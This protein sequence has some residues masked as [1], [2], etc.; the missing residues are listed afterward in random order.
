MDRPARD[1]K[2]REFFS[3]TEVYL[4]DN[5]VTSLRRDV[6]REMTQGQVYRRVIDVACGN[7]GVTLPLIR[8]MEHLTLL[9]LSPAMLAEAR[10]AL[11]QDPGS[12]VSFVQGD[13]MR[14][15]LP[16][17]HYDLVVCLGLLAHVRDPEEAVSR[18]AGITAE[19]GWLL[20]QN[21][22]AAHPYSFFVGAWR[23]L[24]SMIRRSPYPF[25]EVKGKELRAWLAQQGFTEE[26]RYRSILSFLFLSHILSGRNKGWFIRTLFGHPSRPRCQRW[27]NDEII[28]LR[29]MNIRDGQ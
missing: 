15:D 11:P 1:Q 2:V 22:D 4:K 18:L 5:F 24:R 10:K 17:N 14:I 23:A 28:L 19:G 25:N 6:L 16:G 13:L 3:D 26:K 21:T 8:R 27:G 20:L 9:D 7:G 29:K 12:Q